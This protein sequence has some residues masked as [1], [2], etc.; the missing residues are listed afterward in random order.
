MR[1][2][3]DVTTTKSFNE[4]T[5]K[6]SISGHGEWDDLLPDM[7]GVLSIPLF[8]QLALIRTRNLRTAQRV[9]SRS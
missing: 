9:G 4:V 7:H 2:I 6:N 5:W 3:D 1:K 8:T